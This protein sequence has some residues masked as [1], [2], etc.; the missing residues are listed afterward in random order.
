MGILVCLV[1]LYLSTCIHVCASM[2]A[3]ARA[4][5]CVCGG[6]ILGVGVGVGVEGGADSV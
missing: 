1:C 6:V 2:L 5:V 3:P 4:H